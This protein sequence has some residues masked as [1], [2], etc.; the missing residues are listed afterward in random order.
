MPLKFVREPVEKK[1]LSTADRKNLS[2]SD[3]VFPKERRYPIPDESHARNALA[4]VAQ[5]GT[6]KEKRKVR[7]AVARRYPGIEQSKAESFEWSA[8]LLVKSEE[9]QIVYGV[10]LEPDLEDSQGDVISAEEIEKAAHDYMEH[11]QLADE[12]HDESEAGAVLVENYL[13]KEDHYVGDEPVRKG[14]WVQAW[15]VHD[16]ELWAAIKSEELTGFS[17]GGYAE[18]IPV[19]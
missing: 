7:A 17:I 13:A 4:R 19:A 8:Q 11:S 12:Q 10:V 18:R 9:Q 16:P 1:T 2:S 14:A 5:N 6:P 3:Y 15:K